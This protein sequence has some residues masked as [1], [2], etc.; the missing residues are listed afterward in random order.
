MVTKGHVIA[1][2]GTDHAYLPIYLVSEGISPKAVASDVST[3]AVQKASAH[4][5][6]AGLSD[7][8]S[9]C[10]RDGLIGYSPLEADTLVITGMGGPLIIRILEDSKETAFSFKEIILSPQSE[11]ASVRRWL[12]QQGFCLTDEALIRDGDHDY[13]VLKLCPPQEGQT[14][15]YASFTDDKMKRITAYRFGP[16]LLTRKDPV[17]KDYLKREIGRLD[18]AI[19]CVKEGISRE[20]G[21]RKHHRLR[22]LEDEKEAACSALMSLTI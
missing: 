4:V 2:V 13:F 8:I 18:K 14:D 10:V 22:Q 19:A 17:L 16:I 11:I 15:V 9:V 1:D 5:Q 20:A 3:A 21:E 7:Q 12:Y 6:E